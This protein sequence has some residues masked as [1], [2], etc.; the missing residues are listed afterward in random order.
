MPF[1]WPFGLIALALI[2]LVALGWYLGSPLFVDRSVSKAP[3]ELELG[4][5]VAMEPR[6]VAQGSF[7]VVDTIHHGQGTASVLSVTPLH[8]RRSTP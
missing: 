1:G 3:P 2:V 8:N 6:L 4:G 7:G 5:I